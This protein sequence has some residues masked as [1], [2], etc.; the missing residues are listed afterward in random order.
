M[1]YVDSRST[2]ALQRVPWPG[3]VLA[4]LLGV[5]ALRM[6]ETAWLSQW[7]LSALTV[8]IVIGLAVGNVVGARLPSAFSPGLALAQ[9]HLLRA[10]VVLYGLRLSFQDVAD[11]GAAGLLLDVFV[12]VSTLAL[13][14]WAGR[15]CFGLDRDT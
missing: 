7:H 10:G 6:A 3:L 12:V 1:A 8:A 4:A 13:G 11:V 15:R 14:T 5:F 9:R 2:P